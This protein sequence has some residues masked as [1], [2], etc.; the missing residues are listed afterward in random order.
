[1]TTRPG[2]ELTLHDRLSQL[3]FASACKLL[4]PAGA[5]LIRRGGRL[6]PEVLEPVLVGAK[7]ATIRF[8]SADVALYLSDDRPGGLHW[9]CSRCARACEH[10]GAALSAVLED[11][12]ALGLA[13]PP[14]D[15]WAMPGDLIARAIEERAERAQLEKMAVRSA[16]P[17]V[18]W[19]DYTVTSAESGRSYRVALRSEQR[20]DSYCSCPDFRK[21]TLG[22]C[23][24]ILHVLEKA[25]RRFPAAARE[26]VNP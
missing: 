11:K 21:N 10:V 18:P 3:D 4:G 9:R 1:M 2:R 8:G 7:R 19:T 16:D 6:V 13:D 24:H 12:I 14:D 23:K 20:G 26:G 17:A 25:R 5:A 22:T 15:D